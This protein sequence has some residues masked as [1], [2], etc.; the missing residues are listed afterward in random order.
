MNPSSFEIHFRRGHGNLHVRPKGRLDR[1]A[2]EELLDLLHNR[3]DGAGLVFVDTAALEDVQPL[4]AD[5]FRSTIESDAVIPIH[6]LLFKGIKGFDIAPPGCRVLV[7]PHKR[8]SGG[9]GNCSGC[10]CHSGPD[11][12]PS[13]RAKCPAGPPVSVN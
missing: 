9:K 2:A 13:P 8:C 11:P 1:R 5:T 4:A 6:R 7:T 3:Y 10:S 12:S